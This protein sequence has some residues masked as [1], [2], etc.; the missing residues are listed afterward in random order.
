MPLRLE[1][2]WRSKLQLNADRTLILVLI[3]WRTEII[4]F[5]GEGIPMYRVSLIFFYRTDNHLFVRHIRTSIYS[6]Y[7]P[8]YKFIEKGC[9]K[10]KIDL[11]V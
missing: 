1:W 6:Q 9:R 10:S 8:E 3:F 5:I 11:V 4:E 7:P 2:Y